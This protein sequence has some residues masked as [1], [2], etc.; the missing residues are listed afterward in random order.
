MPLSS[1]FPPRHPIRVVLSSTALL[2]F[3]SVRKAAALA[4][5]QSGVAAFFI[6]GVT[7]S[8]LGAS[9]GWFVLAVTVLAVLI[10]AIDIESWA[11]LIAGGFVSRVGLA[12]GAGAG[13][14]AAALALI[15]R[16]LLGA[17]AS[18]VAGHYVAAVVVS[19]I[20]EQR[21]TGRPASLPGIR[22]AVV[23]SALAGGSSRRQTGRPCDGA[24][25]SS[26][27]TV[28]DPSRIGRDIDRNTIARSVWI[29]AG[30]LLLTVIW[31]VFT[32]VFS[33]RAPVPSLT[34]A[35]AL[36]GLTGWPVLDVI[37]FVALGI[38][39]ALPAV[40]SGEALVRAAHDFPP[41]R[42]Q[43]LRRTSLLVI[44]FAL[45]ITT[46][47][48]FL[49]ARLVPSG[50]VSVWLNAPLVGVAQHVAGPGCDRHL[51]QRA[52]GGVAQHL[53]GPDG[54]DLLALAL[55]AAALLVLLPAVHGALADAERMLHR[56]ST[57]GALPSG[58]ASLHTR[59]GTP[60][61][62][63]DIAA[64]AT[65]LLIVAGGGRTRMAG[66][67]LRRRHR[68]D[69]GDDGCCACPAARD[70]AGH[71]AISHAHKSPLP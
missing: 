57:D 44:A 10:R 41:P 34:S 22:T 38:A 62:G 37:R 19:A 43:A 9:A 61:R 68:D 5:A 3:L 32:V 11:L 45:F 20:G 28:V 24:G 46:L 63:A 39:L 55:A 70:S 1:S 27:R 13:R 50:E 17:S 31:G 35:A 47:G 53:A 49:F 58:L 18:V 56:A 15:E 51:A 12:F 48:T 2:P 33:R 71:A 4:I 54:S 52:V 23:V 60:A 14:F 36:R 7:W 21:F 40:G 16:L 6:A 66:A 59:F 30:I 69:A 64:A 42:V 29:G 26:D 67:S 25:F 8:A 65:V